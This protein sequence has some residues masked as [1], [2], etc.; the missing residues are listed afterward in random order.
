MAKKEKFRDKYASM[1]VIGKSVGLSSRAV[2]NKLKELGL[3]QEDGPPSKESLDSGIAV[4]A[5]LKDGT[6][7][8]M[9]DKRAVIKKLGKTGVNTSPEA[10]K[11]FKVKNV[12]QEALD[13]ENVDEDDPMA[14]KLARIAGDV[15]TSA[16]LPQIDD[17]IFENIVMVRK[18]IHQAK[19]R[20]HTKEWLLEWVL[21][22]YLKLANKR[23]KELDIEEISYV[24]EKSADWQTLERVTKLDYCNL[25]LKNRALNKMVVIGAPEKVTQRVAEEIKS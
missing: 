1:T 15:I 13:M 16:V 20:E 12:I 19:G 17:N 25:F 11:F 23:K 22:R 6:K 7:H 14:D 4:F 9:W 3:R 24:I 10:R 5:P 18:A 21:R 8:Y 2:G